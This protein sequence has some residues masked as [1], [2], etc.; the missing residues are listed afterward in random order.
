MTKTSELIGAELDKWTALADECIPVMTGEFS[1][2]EEGG[3]IRD[4]CYVNG[5][6][7][8]PSTNWQ[9]GGPLIEKY[10]IELQTSGDGLWLANIWHEVEC[11]SAEGG[12]TPL[13][14]AMRCIVASKYGDEVNDI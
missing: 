5:F 4:E 2:D 10:N 11:T 1:H 3:D 9:Q 6:L 13:I 8:E 12:E 7:Y 14:A